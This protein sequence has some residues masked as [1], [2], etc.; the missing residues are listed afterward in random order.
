MIRHL[1]NSGRNRN[2]GMTGGDRCIREAVRNE[3]EDG[4]SDRQTA[5]NRCRTATGWSQHKEDGSH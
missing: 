3:E 1:C 5:Y 2:D 4:F